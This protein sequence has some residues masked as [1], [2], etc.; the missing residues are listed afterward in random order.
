MRCGTQ[1]LRYIWLSHATYQWVTPCIYISIYEW[2]V[3]H[4]N[5]S[6]YVW[7]SCVTYDWVM[8]HINESRR[9]SIYECVMLHINESSYV[10]K[11]CVTSTYDWVMPHIHESRRIS[12]SHDNYDINAIGCSNAKFFIHSTHVTQYTR[13]AHN[14]TPHTYIYIYKYMK[15]CSHTH[16]RTNMHVLAGHYQRDQ[17]W[18]FATYTNMCI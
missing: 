18:K 11:S 17:R 13:Y 4:I 8:P 2:V 6:S 9:V 15:I 10:W 7:K 5:E 14:T 1:E 3:L 12:M 16:T